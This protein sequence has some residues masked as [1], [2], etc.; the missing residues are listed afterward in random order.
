MLSNNIE[1]V[2]QYSMYL[3]QM[4]SYLSHVNVCVI[5]AENASFDKLTVMKNEFNNFL[6]N[7]EKNIGNICFIIGIDKF[8]NEYKKEENFNDK[9]VKAEK[10]GVCSFVFAENVKKFSNQEYEDWYKQYASKENGI[11]VGNGFDSQYTLSAINDSC[12]KAGFC[13]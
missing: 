11:W 8:V 12:S 9:L 3:T 6:D 10:S 4:L 1:E 2:T 7:L 5:D 13:E